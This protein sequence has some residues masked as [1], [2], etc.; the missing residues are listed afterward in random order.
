MH[1]QIP[2]TPRRLRAN[3]QPEPGGV[4][5]SPLPREQRAGTA[6]AAPAPWGSLGLTVAHSLENRIAVFLFPPFFS[7]P[8][9]ILIYLISLYKYKD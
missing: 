7:P 2:V 6:P 5:R 4:C 9:I 3:L 8:Q 1:L